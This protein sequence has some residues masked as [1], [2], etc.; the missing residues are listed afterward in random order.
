MPGAI[1]E[2]E[3]DRKLAAQRLQI[4][5]SGQYGK[6]IELRI[7]DEEKWLRLFEQNSPIYKWNPSGLVWAKRSQ[8]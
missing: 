8:C 2:A 6:L 5:L 4:S 7:P 3:G 1:K